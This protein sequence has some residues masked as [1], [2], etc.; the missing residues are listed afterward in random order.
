MNTELNDVIA[1][2]VNG[3]I[4]DEECWNELDTISNESSTLVEK[5]EYDWDSDSYDW[6]DWE[7]EASRYDYL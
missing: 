4:T 7:M 3:T 5:E 2:Y 1:L 6:I